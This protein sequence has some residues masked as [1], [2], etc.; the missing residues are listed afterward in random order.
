MLT[1]LSITREGAPLFNPHLVKP[2]ATE[3]RIVEGGRMVHESRWLKASIPAKAIT[4]ISCTLEVDV[5][6]DDSCGASPAV[7]VGNSGQI[8]HRYF[9]F[10]GSNFKIKVFDHDDRGETATAKGEVQL[11]DWTHLRPRSCQQRIHVRP[12]PA[13]M[14]LQHSKI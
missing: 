13:N 14:S 2:A 8:H 11:H 9:R 3:C 4:I 10:A 6:V 12:T 1:A 7:V 5:T